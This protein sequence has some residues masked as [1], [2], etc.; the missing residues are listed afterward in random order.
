MRRWLLIGAVLLV[1]LVLA[2]CG[3]G[4]GGGGEAADDPSAAATSDDVVTIQLAEQNGSGESGTATL[5]AMDDRTLVVLDLQNPTTGSQPAHVHEGQ[6][7]PTLDPAPL[8][9]LLNVANGHSETVVNVPL[10]ELTAGGLAINIHHSDSAFER[11]VAC[12]NLPGGDGGS[13]PVDDGDTGGF[14]Y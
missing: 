9:G 3:G 11:F 5:T 1:P 7:G 10:S 6:C 12:G 14:D 13:A 4:N 8:H 2:A